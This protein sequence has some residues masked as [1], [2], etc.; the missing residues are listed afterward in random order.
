MWKAVLGACLLGAVIGVFQTEHP[1]R[2]A[3][4]FANAKLVLGYALS[5]AIL[6]AIV[7]S[8]TAIRKSVA[9]LI[10]RKHS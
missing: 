4:I 3:N 7:W 6:M 2:G 1:W 10:W 9:A 8:L 5:V